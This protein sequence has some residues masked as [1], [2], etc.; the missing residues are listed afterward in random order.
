MANSNSK[1]GSVYESTNYDNFKLVKGNR[2][3]KQQGAKF[4][5]LL[6]S[7]EKYGQ[8][9]PA[10]VTPSLEVVD[11]Q[12]RL[13]ACETLHVPFKYYVGGSNVSAEHIAEAN[14]AS[15]WG[16]KE[17]INFYATQTN[18]NASSY[19]LLQALLSA[20]KI[21]TS[22][23]IAIAS[24]REVGALD[25]VGINNGSFKLS[26]SEYDRIKKCLDELQELGY[27]RWI[28]EN[29][30]ITRTYWLSVTYA[31][32]HPKVNCDRLI[33]LMFENSYKI[34]SSSKIYGMLRVLTEIY[35]KG[36]PKKN[37]V[38]LDVDYEQGLYRG[39]NTKTA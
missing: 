4:D 31:W 23:I 29:K 15:K 7:I 22:T 21:P 5:R 3:I 24:A 8:I 26:F 25:Q 34:P 35:N 30:M 13:K 11:G 6:K 28:L 17:Y 37:R 38:Y 33:K 32:K 20:Y 19:K 9:E 14:S 39:W 27:M 10:I 2:P 16:A 12:H 36:L 18:D 1:I